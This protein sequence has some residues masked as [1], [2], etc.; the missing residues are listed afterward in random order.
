MKNNWFLYAGLAG[1]LIGINT[2]MNNYFMNK[3][4][5]PYVM[6]I[7]KALFFLF[8]SFIIIIIQSHNG[9]LTLKDCVELE[10]NDVGLM[11]IGGLFTTLIMFY[12]FMAVYGVPNTAYSTSIKGSVALTTG[13]ILSL[14]FLQGQFNIKAILGMIFVFCGGYLIKNNS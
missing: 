4:I 6:L 1:L 11:F 14:I 2:V 7:L 13:F 8:F 5:N 9:N 10:M 3:N 12:S